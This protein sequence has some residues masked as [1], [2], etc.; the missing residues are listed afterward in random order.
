VGDVIL[1]IYAPGF[2]TGYYILLIL[3]VSRLL[4]GYAEQFIS[5]IIAVNR[6]RYSVYT[7]GIFVVTNLSL[8]AGLTWMFG[9]YGAAIATT[10][11]VFIALILSYHYA[12]RLVTVILPVTEIAKQWI[13]AGFMTLN[14]L[15]GRLLFGDSI[16]IV[17]VLVGV[18]ASAY[19]ISLLVLSAQFRTTVQE[20][21]PFATQYLR[22]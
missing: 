6:P 14:V 15:A 19:L 8:N 2:D 9:W 17:V 20:N 16:P 5:V 7:N 4:H 11:S 13:A 18:G 22:P 3:T 10:F 21:V 1:S 12:A